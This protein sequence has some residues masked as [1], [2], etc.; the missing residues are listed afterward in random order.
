M[1]TYLV[2]NLILI[3]QI[4]Q[5][6]IYVIVSFLTNTPLSLDIRVYHVSFGFK[7]LAVV[8]QTEFILVKC[9]LECVRLPHRLDLRRLLQANQAISILLCPLIFNPVY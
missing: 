4:L 2:P 7:I 9:L 3:E 5:L 8:T 6:A 1:P